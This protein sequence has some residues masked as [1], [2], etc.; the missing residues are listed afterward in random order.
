MEQFFCDDVGGK[1]NSC[2]VIIEILVFFDC[3][4]NMKASFKQNILSSDD[5]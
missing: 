3:Y 4:S 5:F 1:R 2:E